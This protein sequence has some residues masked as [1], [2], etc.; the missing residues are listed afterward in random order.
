MKFQNKTEEKKS[1]MKDIHEIL[2][3][4]KGT[5]VSKS[6]IIVSL[7]HDFKWRGLSVL[8]L[9][10][11][12]E[13]WLEKD[14]IIRIDKHYKGICLI[15]IYYSIKA[16][17]ED[18][19]L[20]KMKSSIWEHKLSKGDYSKALNLWKNKEFMKEL[21]HDNMEMSVLSWEIYIRNFNM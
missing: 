5:K 6:K 7:R 14:E 4:A 1:M 13:V 19:L 18:D 10:G 8:F 9:N 17:N 12:F 15:S 21:I 11:D 20:N 3:N 2:K 16:D